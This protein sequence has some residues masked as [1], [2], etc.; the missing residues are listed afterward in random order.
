[1]PPTTDPELLALEDACRGRFAIE[2]E[3]GRGGMGVV[4]LARDLA[5]DRPVAIKLLPPTLARV[6]ALRER[7]LR[8][9]RTAA[10]LAHPNVVPVHAVEAHGDVVFFVMGYVDGESLARRVQ[11]AGPLAPADAARVLRDVAW[12]LAYAHGRGVV[13]RDVKPDNILLDRGSSRALVT[14]FGIARVADGAAPL[15]RDGHVLGTAHYMSPE[16]AAGEPLDGRSDLYAL[17]ASGFFALTGAPPIDAPT[18]PALLARQLLHPAPPVASRRA[19][20]PAPLAAAVDR[21]LAK[22]PDARFPSAEALA[23]AL[24]EAQGREADVPPPVRNFVR[25]AEQS[26]MMTFVVLVLMGTATRGAGGSG[27][28]AFGGVAG[29]LGAFAA[30]L[31]WRARLLLQLGYTAGDVS[32]GFLL[33]GEARDAE[34]AAMHDPARDG[35]SARRLAPGWAALVLVLGAALFGMARRVAPGTAAGLAW[36]AGALG[37][38]LLAIFA[39]TVL[40]AGRPERDRRNAR[41]WTRP[42]R[43]PFT[44]WFFRIAGLGLDAPP[45]V[46]GRTPLADTPS[47]DVPGAV[48]ARHPDLPALLRAGERTLH[49]LRGR[50]QALEQLLAESGAAVGAAMTPAGVAEPGPTTRG[51]LLSRRVQLVDET[52]A[53]LAGVQDARSAVLAAAENVRIQLA[54]TRAGLA[55]PGDLAPDVAAL[56]ALVARADAPGTAARLDAT[57]PEPAPAGA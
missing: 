15:T 32:R 12:A 22:H 48:L 20:L 54:R 51:E 21:C 28:A 35:T 25:L 36:Q 29:A 34:I 31:G 14:D 41:M 23:D 45:P 50:E 10:G 46:A 39:F 4:V 19:G 56:Q 38:L 47:A 43:G 3:L 49:A 6:P 37:V 17:G 16:Q 11:R 30:D 18:V 2:R 1:M 53:A 42:W 33:E 5:L 7:F 57:P 55:A 52:R 27:F 9:A 26:T 24:A 13:H 44:F 8:E 40:V